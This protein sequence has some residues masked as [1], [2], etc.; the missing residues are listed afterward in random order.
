MMDIEKIADEAEMIINGYAY[1]RNELG[2]QVINLN[3][4]DRAA[5]LSAQGE[6]LIT[7]MDD[8]ELQIVKK[9]YMNNKIL[10]EDA[11]A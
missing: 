6:T 8:I 3:R 7:A 9:Y 1:T 4:P 5:L 10:L 11:D 2:I